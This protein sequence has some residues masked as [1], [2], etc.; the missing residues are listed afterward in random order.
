MARRADVP[1]TI[2]AGAA[3]SRT[4][5]RP[6]NT[7]AVVPA[8]R[9]PRRATTS[10]TRAGRCTSPSTSRRR[11]RRLNAIFPLNGFA[12]N[13]IDNARQD[14]VQHAAHASTRAFPSSRRRATSRS[15]RSTSVGLSRR[16]RWSATFP[17]TS[18]GNQLKQ[19]AKIIKLNQT[20]AEREPPG[21][22]LLDRRLRHA[23]GRAPGPHESLRADLDGDDRVLRRDGRAEAST[24][25]SRRSRCP[26]S[27]GRSRPPA[28][29]LRRLG[30]RAGAVTS[31]SWAARSRRP[32]STAPGLRTERRS[33]TTPSAEPQPTDRPWPHAS[34]R[35]PPTSTPR[36]LGLWLG[37]TPRTLNTIFPN[38]YTFPTTR[39]RI[40]P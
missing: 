29:A 21:L 5:S 31:S 34:R 3:S 25:T 30:P 22:L 37:A 9:L 2:S 13:A 18:L 11:R 24:T 16:I 15:R 32:T 1:Q 35:R 8:G 6:C 36:P 7:G 23:P 10:S 20:P 38:L 26:T 40:P 12:A 27:A 4:S 28:R 39:P 19:V 17:N 33:R 14:G